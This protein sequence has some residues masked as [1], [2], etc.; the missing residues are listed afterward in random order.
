MINAVEALPIRAQVSL[1][2]TLL[3]LS[4][5]LFLMSVVKRFSSKFGSF[6]P[7][8]DNVCAVFIKSFNN[9]FGPRLFFM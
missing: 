9:A 3:F 6:G 5:I 7:K 2:L 8:C 1:L 4:R